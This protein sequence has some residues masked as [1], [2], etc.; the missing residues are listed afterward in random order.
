MPQVHRAIALLFNCSSDP[1]N[2]F[3]TS[4]GI[5][6]DEG[7]GGLRDELDEWP[8]LLRPEGA[9]Q[10]HAERVGVLDAGDEGLGGL[11]GERPGGGGGIQ[12]Y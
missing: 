10:A 8:H 5:A 4:I 11:A 6:D 12:W 2:N 3:L 7:L 9:V 1:A